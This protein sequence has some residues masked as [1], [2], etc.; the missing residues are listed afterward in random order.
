[1]PAYAIIG[2]QWGDEGKGKVVDFLSEG[3]HIV[4][5]FSGGNN[6]GHTVVTDRGEFK[7][8]LI[9]SGVLWPHVTGIIGNGVVVDPDAL[10]EEISGLQAQSVDMSRL[11]VSDRAHVIMPYHVALDHLEEQARGEGA[12]GTTGKGIGPAYMDKAARV[13]IRMGDLLD[14]KGL[15][16]S[17]GFI[18]E[19]KNTLI[20]RLYGGAPFSLEELYERCREW[21]R[22]LESFIRPA[23]PVLQEALAKKQ[24]LL[25]EGAQGSMLDLDHGTYPYVTS[26]SS[27]IGGACTGLGISPKHIQEVIGIYKAYTTRVGSGAL[28]TELKDEIG[29]AIRERAWEYG[30]T[31]GRPRRCGWFDA[32]AARYSATLN[33]MTSAVLTRLDVLDGFSPLKICVAYRLNGKVT[34]CFPGSASALEACEPVY[35]EF[36][37]WDRPTAGARH[38]SELPQGAVN[39]V[40]RIEELLGCPLSMV[41]TG[42]DREETIILKPIL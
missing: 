7:F 22:S 12:I 19:Q 29:E 15:L 11:L 35:E 10:L 3:A 13:G 41:S 23:G 34:D 38:I 1:M 6:A 4:A 24:R 36:P 28:P 30:T 37:G 8:H 27:T 5:R 20:T 16:S 39:F 40:R 26:S 17:L 42:P 25:L 14:E 31:T 32:V 33:G 9:P 21:G 18:L 2:G